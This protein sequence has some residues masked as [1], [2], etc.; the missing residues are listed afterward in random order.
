M[1]R[2][3]T[4]G[5]RQPGSI[6]SHR[7]MNMHATICIIPRRF[8]TLVSHSIMQ[9]SRFYS[10][11]RAHLK[12]DFQE[13]QLVDLDA[14]ITVPVAFLSLSIPGISPCIAREPKASGYAF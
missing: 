5:Q 10:A 4:V 3:Q 7:A 2:C 9:V 1:C 13:V 12:Q 14:C 6:L 8:P 11:S